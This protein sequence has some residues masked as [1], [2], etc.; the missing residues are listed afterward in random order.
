MDG[1]TKER[2]DQIIERLDRIERL[3]EAYLAE[4]GYT[5]TGEVEVV[6]ASEPQPEA[7][8]PSVFTLIV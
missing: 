4:D 3:L 1:L 5:S 8:V 2:F 7:A 6:I